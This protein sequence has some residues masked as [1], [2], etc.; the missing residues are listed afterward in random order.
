MERR[1]GEP[2]ER[3]ED[4]ERR[5]AEECELAAFHAASIN[6]SLLLGVV[7]ARVDLSGAAARGGAIRGGTRG[8]SAGDA[9]R[10]LQVLVDL[11]TRLLHRGPEVGV[12]RLGGE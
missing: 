9:L 4:E 8:R 3:P 5:Q 11:A 1:D 6:E 12:L 10:E 2:G 7:D